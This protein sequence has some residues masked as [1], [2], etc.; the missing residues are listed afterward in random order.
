M[1]GTWQRMKSTGKNFAQIG[2]IFVATECSLEAY[3]GHYGLNNTFSAGCITGGL[4][5]LRAGVQPA[6]IGGLGFGFFSVAIDM[7]MK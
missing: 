2:M 3:T 6:I 7:Y 5:G 4:L 1:K